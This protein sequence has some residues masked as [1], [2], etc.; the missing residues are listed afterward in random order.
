MTFV[1]V[2]QF[3]KQAKKNIQTTNHPVSPS[4]DKVRE[5]EREKGRKSKA[6]KA[7]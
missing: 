2:A 7:G 4:L 5:E 6:Q 1:R 3:Q